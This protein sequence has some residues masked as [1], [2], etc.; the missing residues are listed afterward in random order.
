GGLG[1]LA[2][3]YGYQ[4]FETGLMVVTVIVLIVIVTLVQ[5]IGDLV[6]RRLAPRGTSRAQTPV[7]IRLPW[8]ARTAQEATI[9][10]P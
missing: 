8:S 1:N 5:L 9:A 6:A 3:V 2:I 4:R 7:R 10:K